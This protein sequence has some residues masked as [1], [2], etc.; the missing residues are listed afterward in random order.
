MTLEL[1]QALLGWST[2][3]NLV[4]LVT[5]WLMFA[6]ASDW[7]YRQHSR[8]FELSRERFH[9]I[10]YSGMAL[11][12]LLLWVFNLTPYLALRILL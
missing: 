6:T 9:A 11:L 10:H 7:I 1:L 8:W 5:W 3:I 2:L 4:L 12:K